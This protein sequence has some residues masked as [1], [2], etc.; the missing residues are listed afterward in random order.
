MIKKEEKKNMMNFITARL[1]ENK[2]YEILK[3]K[4]A[5]CE[6]KFPSYIKFKLKNDDS[7]FYFFLLHDRKTPIK[8]VKE[9]QEW[10]DSKGWFSSH[11][12]YKNYKDFFVRLGKRAN[13]KGDGRSLKDYTDEELKNMIHLRDL[14]KLALTQQRYFTTKNRQINEYVLEPHLTYYQPK[15]NKLEESIRIF[16][17]EDVILDYTHLT[18][19][20]PGYYFTPRRENSKY[21]RIVDFNN[22][23][24]I[25]NEEIIIQPYECVASNRKNFYIKPPN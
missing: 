17:L 12:F 9:F 2:K 24:K 25:R 16:P 18:E 10:L 5:M 8:D 4:I 15:T 22:E 20:D 1:E 19:N 6:D 23:R 3:Q 14:E 7:N 11:I 21:Y 13:F